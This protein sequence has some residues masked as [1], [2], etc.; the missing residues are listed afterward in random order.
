M[1]W[2]ILRV[3]AKS[4]ASR[5][6]KSSRAIATSSDSVRAVTEAL[7]GSPSSSAISPK[8]SPACRCVRTTS[9]PSGESTNT[10]T[11]PRTSAKKRSPGSASRRIGAPGGDVAHRGQPRQ[12][13][14][15]RGVEVGEERDAAKHG[16]I[17]HDVFPSPACNRERSRSSARVSSGPLTNEPPDSDSRPHPAASRIA[18]RRAAPRPRR[19]P[20]ARGPRVGAADHAGEPEQQLRRGGP[21]ERRRRAARG[22]CRRPRRAGPGRPPASWAG[23][24]G[25]RGR[26]SRRRCPRPA[27]RAPPGTS[28]RRAKPPPPASGAAP[29]RPGARPRA[30]S[31]SGRPAAP[32]PPG[33]RSAGSSAASASKTVTAMASSPTSR[34]RRPALARVVGVEPPEGEGLAVVLQ[35]AL[36][37]PRRALDVRGPHEHRRRARI[38]LDRPGDTGAR[39]LEPAE[40]RVAVRLRERRVGR[41]REQLLRAGG[42][43]RSGRRERRG[44]RVQLVGLHRGAGAGL[45]SP[46]ATSSATV[47]SGFASASSQGASASAERPPATSASIDPIAPARA[48]GPDAARANSFRARAASPASSARHPSSMET[49]KGP[50][51]PSRG[52]S[53]K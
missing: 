5:A 19:A 32:R 50:V 34:A 43:A 20:Q 24:R 35:G 29:A 26:P 53:G 2:R 11:S 52:S 33:R 27:P 14:Q 3:S 23:C 46:Q 47:G 17:D 12:R 30:S 41:F 18:S 51:S 22:A 15:L 8:K 38:P 13:L 1:V 9:R 37:L 4:R 28:T 10:L 36:L 40:R 45:A 25:A 16:W 39:G 48:E 49:S 21:R 42:E 44:A 7:R 31:T 6:K